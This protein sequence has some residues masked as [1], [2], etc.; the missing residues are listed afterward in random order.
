MG[1]GRVPF[2]HEGFN[3][4]MSMFP[5]HCRSFA[6]NVAMSRGAH[7]PAKVQYQCPLPPCVRSAPFLS[8]ATHYLMVIGGGGRM[9]QEPGPSEKF[10]WE[11]HSLRYL[12]LRKCLWSSVSDAALRICIG[13]TGW[14]EAS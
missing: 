10:G 8:A 14:T 12:G 7:D 9:D 4:R 13:G 6:E 3:K 5:G 1:E 2:G 11:L